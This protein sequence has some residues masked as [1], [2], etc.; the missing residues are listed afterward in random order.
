MEKQALYIDP[1][2][3]LFLLRVMNIVMLDTSAVVLLLYVCVIS[4][5]LAVFF[6]HI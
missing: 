1:R 3:K 6:C 5:W 2:T 4:V